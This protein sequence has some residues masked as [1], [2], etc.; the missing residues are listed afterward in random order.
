M[1]F[2]SASQSVK[3]YFAGDSSGLDRTLART[4]TRLKRFERVAGRGST[5][6]SGLIGGFSKGGVIAAG[7]GVAVLGLK[8][9]TKAVIE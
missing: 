3:L 2:G 4:E 6:N 7:L 8:N 5:L 9:V 1:A